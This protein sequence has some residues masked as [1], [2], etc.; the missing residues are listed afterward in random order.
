MVVI[1]RQQFG[2]ACFQPALGGTGL[3]LRTVAVATGVVGDLDL[4]AA[5]TAE[6]VTTERGTAAALNGRHHLELVET[7]VSGMGLAPRRTLVA[8]DVRDL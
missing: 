3:T 4:R 5:F 8:E 2:L 6:H 1:H 7:N